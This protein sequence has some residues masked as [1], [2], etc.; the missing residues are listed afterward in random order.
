MKRPITILLLLLPAAA[1]ARSDESTWKFEDRQTLDRTFPVAAG[2]NVAKL[3]VDNVHGYIHVTGNGGSQ[4]QVKVEEHI[5]AE[6]KEALADARKDVQFD[7]TQDGNAVKLRS[8]DGG[9]GSRYRVVFDCEI[10]VPVGAALDLHTLNSAIQV[11]NSSGDFKVGA[12]NGKVEMEEIGGSGQ[13]HTL[14]GAVRIVFN[15]N[16]AKE[17]SFHTL[18]G[19][20]DVY[21]HSSPD[22][23]MAFQTL[24][25]NVYSDFDVTT[26]PVTVKGGGSGTRF[27]YRSGGS[28]KVRAGKGGPELSFHTL[29]GA[30][31]LH[32]KA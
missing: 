12:L 14:N 21:F 8:H 25:G 31:R 30:I 27:M 7:M 5:L 4:I 23:D 20:I 16:P 26:V 11:K 13:A 15:R 28:M 22:A 29:N 32:S 9:S 18:N 3:L 19:S 6:S 24:H 1:L 2:E 17:S 10:Q